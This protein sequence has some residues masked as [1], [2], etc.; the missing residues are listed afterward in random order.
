MKNTVINVQDRTNH[1][2]IDIHL[3]NKAIIRIETSAAWNE[4]KVTHIQWQDEKMVIKPY[5]GNCFDIICT[6]VK[7]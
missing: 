5:M 2:Q 6:D 1:D 7:Y 4:I 3:P